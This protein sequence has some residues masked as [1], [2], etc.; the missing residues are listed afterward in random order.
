[1]AIRFK[2]VVFWGRP[3][4]HRHWKFSLG[5]FTET[6]GTKSHGAMLWKST[7]QTQSICGT[8]SVFLVDQKHNSVSCSGRGFLFVVRGGDSSD[9][10]KQGEA[11]RVRN[12]HVQQSVVIS[13]LHPEI[14]PFGFC[15]FMTISSSPPPVIYRRPIKG[16]KNSLMRG[17]NCAMYV[18]A[19][20]R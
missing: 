18:I 13:H 14:R 16:S 9:S 15:L 7:N 3:R 19:H 5:I 1:M 6:M 12:I 11:G 10:Q 2:C 17:C 4:V 20:M 8:S